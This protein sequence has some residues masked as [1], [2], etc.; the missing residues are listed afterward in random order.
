MRMKPVGRV[1]THLLEALAPGIKGHSLERSHETGLG[2]SARHQGQVLFHG[3]AIPAVLH[4]PA[5]EALCG[6]NRVEEEGLAGQLAS[7]RPR[8]GSFTAQ[9]LPPLIYGPPAPPAWPAHA[10]TSSFQEASRSRPARPHQHPPAPPSPPPA[11]L[12]RRRSLQSL[13]RRAPS[14]FYTLQS[15][16]PPL[17]QPLLPCSPSPSPAPPR[18]RP[19]SLPRASLGPA[20][21]LPALAPPPTPAPPSSR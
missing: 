14:A 10:P 12:Q 4:L 17:P 3:P 2:R 9:P 6:C 7:L 1:R 11:P 5:S 19:P 16:L 20:P 8:P 13:H 18:P 21:R 15:R